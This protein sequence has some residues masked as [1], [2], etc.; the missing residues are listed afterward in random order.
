MVIN[1]KKR[2]S[3]AVKWKRGAASINSIRYWVAKKFKAFKECV[4]IDPILNK[5][6]FQR[7]KTK[8]PFKVNVIVDSVPEKKSKRI[9]GCVYDSRYLLVKLKE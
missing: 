8:P 4:F 7:G 5:I 6:I 1:L 2:V 9:A 3:T